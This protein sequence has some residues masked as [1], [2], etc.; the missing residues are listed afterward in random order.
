MQ[1]CGTSGC[2]QL[3]EFEGKNGHPR[4]QQKPKNKEDKSPR[5]SVSTHRACHNHHNIQLD[6][7]DLLDKSGFAWNT[8]HELRESP[9]KEQRERLVAFDQENG[10]CT[11]PQNKN[12]VDDDACV[13]CGL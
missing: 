8:Q 6:R 3:V 5:V 10:H 2:E 1:V 4:V 13:G 11:A 12:E 7:K 9:W